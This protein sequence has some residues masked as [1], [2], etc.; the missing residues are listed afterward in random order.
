MEDDRILFK[1]PWSDVLDSL[2][3]FAVGLSFCIPRRFEVL[4]L[5]PVAAKGTMRDEQ[6]SVDLI[7]WQWWHDCRGLLQAYTGEG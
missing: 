1:S 5:L 7:R 4:H 6:R 2:F 3:G